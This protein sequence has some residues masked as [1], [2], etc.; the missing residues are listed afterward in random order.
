[1]LATFS[2]G[3]IAGAIFAEK[4]YVEG[5]VFRGEM[6]V[7][8]GEASVSAV[9]NISPVSTFGGEIRYPPNVK[10][11]TE[12]LADNDYRIGFQQDLHPQATQIHITADHGDVGAFRPGGIPS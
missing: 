1:M 3:T 2:R 9:L 6:L 11:F 8:P 10:N 7:P 4:L 12:I 5:L